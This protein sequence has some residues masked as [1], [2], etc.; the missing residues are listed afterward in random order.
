MILLCDP[1]VAAVHG[2]DDGAPLVDLR[3][4]PELRLDARAADPAGAYA[5]LRRPVVDRLLAAQRALPDGL[6]LLIVEGYRPHQA[7]LDIFTGYREELRRSH[8]DWSPERLY[9]ETTE[10]V[11]PVEVAPHSTGGAV[12][13][14]LCTVDGVELDMGTAVDATPEASDNACFTA[15]SSIGADARRHRQIM[16][17][18]LRGAGLVNYPTEWW[19]WLYGD[20][21]WALLTGAP[22]TRYGPV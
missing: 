21:Y 19:H 16:A 1:R 15:A 7:Q 22:C 17:A 6:R 20:R 10:F 8:P 2:A 9:R 4:V 3:E 18:A 12:D 5:R 11:S 14:T 13:L